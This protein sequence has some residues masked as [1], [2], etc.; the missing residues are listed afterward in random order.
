MTKVK[1]IHV[2][3]V[4]AIS[5][6]RLNLNGATAI[7]YAGNNKG[8]STLLRTLKDRLLKQKPPHLV[9]QGETDG[10]YVMEFTTGERIEWE[11]STK[12]KAGEK[13]TMISADGSKTNLISEIIDW[14]GP[15]DFDIDKFLQAQPAQQ[16]KTLEK[17]LGLDFTALDERHAKA[18]DDRKY[19]NRDVERLE[20]LYKGQVANRELPTEPIPIEELQRELLGVEAHNLRYKTLQEKEAE[21]LRKRSRLEEELR[22]VNEELS[23]VDDQ[24]SDAS[25]LPKSEEDIIALSSKIEELKTQNERITENN[26]VIKGL[27]ELESCRETAHQKDIVVKDIVKEKED[28]IRSANLPEGF[29][30][31]EEGILYEGLP[32]DKS[33]LSSSRIYIAALKLASLAIGHVRMLHFDASM[34]DNESLKA[35]LAWANENDMQLGVEMVDRSGGDVRYE[36][37]EE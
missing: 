35:V 31:D 14:F 22:Q 10:L 29:S 7:I 8:K 21:L 23:L 27:A 6:E 18:L 12:T 19:A 15:A 28:L 24:L 4:K 16:R 3:N 32:L 5:E 26:K 9:K 30:F 33:Q 13:L 36:I 37:V 2:K 17:L 34:L 20:A 1:T 11:L 25:V